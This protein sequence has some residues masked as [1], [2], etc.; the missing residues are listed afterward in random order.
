MAEPTAS[1]FLEGAGDVIYAAARDHP[2]GRMAR[3]FCEALWARYAPLAD[4]HFR[5]DARTNFLQ[6]FWEMYLGV[7]LID[8]GIQLQR[9]GAEGPEFYATLNGR[10]VWFEAIAPRQGQGP[11]RVPDLRLGEAQYV[12]TEKILLRFTSALE[13]KRQRYLSAVAKGIIRSDDAYVLAL[14]SRGIPHASLND[15]VPYFVQAFLP[16]GPLTANID[17]RTLE[18]TETYYAYR[19]AVKKAND[20]EISTRTFLDPAASFCSAVLHSSVDCANHPSAMGADFAVLHNPNAAVEVPSALFSWCEQIYLR[21]NE[22][23]REPP[24]ETHRQ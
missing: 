15:R 16:F 13:A 20:T 4:P 7:A 12:P 17:S 8:R 14:D 9:Y 5:E 18:I 2:R 1:F 22:L 19:A 24:H 23:H 11:D 10:R 6:R 3:D 21:G